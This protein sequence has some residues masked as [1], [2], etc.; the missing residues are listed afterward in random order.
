M[1]FKKENDSA[2]SLA[3]FYSFSRTVS[4]IA[5][6]CFILGGRGG[7]RGGFGKKL[8]NLLELY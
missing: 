1:D 7:A 3:L 6:N 4:L 8:R 5:I 2:M